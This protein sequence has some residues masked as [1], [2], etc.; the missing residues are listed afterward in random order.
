MC[1]WPTRLQM[2]KEQMDKKFGAP[3]HVVV[4]KGFSYEVTYEVRAGVGAAGGPLMGVWSWSGLVYEA[5]AG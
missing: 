5:P 1:L 2:I 4:G 3:W